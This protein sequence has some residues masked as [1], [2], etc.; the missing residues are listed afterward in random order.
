MSNKTSTDQ[1]RTHRVVLPVRF[2]VTAPV[3]DLLD[4]GLTVGVQFPLERLLSPLKRNDSVHHPKK[5]P[6]HPSYPVSLDDLPEPVLRIRPQIHESVVAQRTVTRVHI[7]VLHVQ[8]AVPTVRARGAREEW[9]SRVAR[10]FITV[11]A[12]VTVMKK[13]VTR[14]L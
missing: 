5:T 10:G 4:Q 8:A 12:A 9:R 1:A 6:L 3:T 11:I 2:R 13:D 14:N 7:P